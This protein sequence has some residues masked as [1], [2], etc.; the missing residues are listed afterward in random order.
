[1][2]TECLLI[3]PG[4]KLLSKSSGLHTSL[5]Y[6]RG[7]LS[8][9]SFLNRKGITTEI[10]VVDNYFSEEYIPDGN[11]EINL[12]IKG[13]IEDIVSNNDILVIGIGFAYTMQFSEV[14]RIARLCKQIAPDINLVVGG[15]HPTFLPVRTLKEIPEI[16]IVVRGEGEWTLA[17]L[18]SK[19]KEG[20][21]LSEVAGITFRDT[22]GKLVSTGDRESGN[23]HELPA[24]NYSL[25]PAGYVKK[26][27]VCIVGSR[28]CP[29]NCT[30]CVE[31]PFWGKKVRLLREANIFC[32]I[33][34]LIDVYK[35]K[36]IAFEDS[37][38]DLR[39]KR[40]FDF[41]DKLSHFYRTD[42]LRA[43]YIQ[44]RVDTISEKG[45]RK[46][47][48]TGIQSI[49]FGMESVSEKVLNMM[50]KKITGEM[51]I[52]ACKLAKN[53]GFYVS[54]FW[55]V[56]HPG[57]N[58][59]EFQKTYDTIDYLLSEGWLDY[60]EAAKF[61]PYPGTP[62][63]RFQEQYGVE[64]LSYDWSKYGRFG[65]ELPVSQLSDFSS[66]DIHACWS[67]LWELALKHKK[68]KSEMV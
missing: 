49:W 40:F 34:Q 36:W 60:I 54:G 39:S 26:V 55:I 44:S 65:R 64:I 58:V 66:E 14:C 38:F 48:D 10:L 61:I 42:S 53:A 35:C 67:M 5:D 24:L 1:M 8:I 51:I 12:K 16:D 4:V 57:D 43:M 28:G 30:F 29:Y 3:A 41:C 19:I 27:R 52:N 7:V 2:E 37:M 50:N 21:S 59:K 13:L 31:R 9:A 45:L 23:T 11:A 18:I 22:S 6:P 62:P 25:L 68:E 20:K 46:A 15:P 63:F 47:R 17:D 33:I 56:G 32:E